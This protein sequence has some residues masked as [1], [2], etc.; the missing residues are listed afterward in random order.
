[1]AKN[2]DTKQE[3]ANKLKRDLDKKRAEFIELIAAFREK[4]RTIG[5]SEQEM[6]NLWLPVADKYTGSLV[7]VANDEAFKHVT[8]ACAMGEKAIVDLNPQAAL[9]AAVGA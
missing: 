6:N 4:S 9:A 8:D 1:M 5:I 3:V 7:A 2:V